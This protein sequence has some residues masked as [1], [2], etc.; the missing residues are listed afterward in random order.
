[1]AKTKKQLDT[2][3]EI[4]YK[5]GYKEVYS[6][7][8]EASEASGLSESAIKIRCNKSI[9]GSANKKDKIHCRW[10]NESTYRSYAAKKSKHKGAGLESDIVKKL[11][12]IGYE[13]VCRAASESKRLDNNKV[14][15]AG[16]CPFA[17]QAKCTQNL[18]NYFTIRE[19]STDPRPLALIWKKVA[20]VNGISPGTL[21][22]MPVEHFYNYLK[23]LNESNSN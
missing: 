2:S 7:L 14:D 22:L 18:P 10:M 6:S 3:V 17:I 15:I 21:V 16:N 1:M 4:I 12:E 11:Q 13:D 5:D 8:I 20:D 23:L 9:D 19:A